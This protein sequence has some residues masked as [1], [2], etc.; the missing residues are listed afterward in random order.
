MFFY[1][2]VR[3]IQKCQERQVCGKVKSRVICF[4]N[5]ELFLV[6][7]WKQHFGPTTTKE[8]YERGNDGALLS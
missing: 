3:N 5:V 8:F 6:G 2:P 1:S 4:I 7:K